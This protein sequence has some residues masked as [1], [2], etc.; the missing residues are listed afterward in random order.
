MHHVNSQRCAGT[1]HP[2]IE[3]GHAQLEAEIVRLQA[4]ARSQRAFV[5]S[6]QDQ[7]VNW[8][9]PRH[10]AIAHDCDWRAGTLARRLKRHLNW[11]ARFARQMERDGYGEPPPPYL[12]AQADA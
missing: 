4:K 3:Y 7:R 8:I 6:L 9:D 10:E 12:M 2:P 1:G 5:R 11:P